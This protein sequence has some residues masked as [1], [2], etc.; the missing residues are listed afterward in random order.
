VSA[1]VF[2]ASSSE[3]ATLTNTFDVAGVATDPTT[4]SLTVTTPS[5]TAT[6]YTYAASEITRTSTG[7]YAKDIA[8]SEAGVWLCLWVGTGTASDAV[9]GTWTVHDTALQRLYCTPEELKSSRGITDTADDAEILAACETAARWIDGACDRSFWRGTDTRTYAPTSLYCLTV[10]DL[11]SVSTLKADAAGDGTFETTWTSGDYQLLP[12][13]PAVGPERRP[14]TQIRAVG[15]YTFPYPTIGPARADLVQVVGV[16]GWPAVPAA[17]KQAAQVLA[18]DFLKLGGMTFG[19]A[20]YG[21]FGPIRA[22]PNPIAAAL[23]APYRRKPV[24]VG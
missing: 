11:V 7:V 3:L 14:Y 13:N 5:G 17:V 15:S 4:V 2:Y 6:T 19:V 22:R 1:T 23:L 10:D 20:N 16:F 8:C 24:L 21:D 12:V 18:G 9:A